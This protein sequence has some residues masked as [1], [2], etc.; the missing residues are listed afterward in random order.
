MLDILIIEDDNELREMLCYLLSTVESFNV[1]TLATGE[2]A[3]AHI[4]SK[5]PR[6]VLLDIQLPVQSGLDILR[7]M[8]ER[9]LPAAVIMMTA[10]DSEL[11]ETNSLVL[12]AHD[13][14]SKPIRSNVLLERIK[15]QLNI[16]GQTER[17]SQAMDQFYLRECDMTLIYNDVVVSLIPSE[18]ELLEVL[19]D[20]NAP[21]TVG[22]I[23]EKIHGFS[24]HVEDRSIYMRISS[25]RKKLYSHIPDVQ[26]INNRRSR[27]FYLAFPV[28][29]I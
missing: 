5:Q 20:S 7:E 19:I 14:V 8:K 12:G 24:H 28:T 15:R 11:S 3:I 22:S 13:Y 16:A 2:G 9:N 25:L 18:Y 21:V 29:K 26:L 17:S 10:N 1:E 6:L 4:E 23:F 27:G